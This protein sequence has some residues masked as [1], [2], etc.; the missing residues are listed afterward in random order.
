MKVVVLLLGFVAYASAG[1]C[2]MEDR[3]EVLSLWESIWSA[4]FSGRRVAIAQAVFNDLFERD[5]SSKDLFKRVNVDD[6][7]SPEFRAHCVRVINGLDTII[8]MSFDPAV[9]G[10][11]LAHLSQQHKERDGVTAAHFDL[12]GES[13]LAVLGQAIPCFNADA[14]SR[15]FDGF[16]AGITEG[17]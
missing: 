8:N 7:D 6:V 11:Q 1:C 5:P 15:C 10:E 14:W 13:F 12:M 16:T 9:L 2:S 3:R 17:L 4:Q